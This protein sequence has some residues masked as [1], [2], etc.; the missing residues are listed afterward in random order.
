MSMTQLFGMLGE[1][2]PAE[3]AALLQRMETYKPP[4]AMLERPDTLES[5]EKILEMLSISGS[6]QNIPSAPQILLGRHPFN[7]NKVEARPSPVHGTGV[8]AT[9]TIKK[10]E[11]VTMYPGDAVLDIKGNGKANVAA[12]EKLLEFCDNSMPKLKEILKGQREYRCNVSGT[13][14]IYG[15]PGFA[16][17]PAY[18]G[19]MIND[20]AT[21]CADPRSIPVYMAAT[22]KKSNCK[23]HACAKNRHIAIL[24][25]KKIKKGRELFISY[26]WAYWVNPGSEK[27]E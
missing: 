19:H 25:T 13:V 12:S 17:D 1:L 22:E 21:A 3:Q 26:G 2:T 6:I 23:F 16:E 15:F 4:A 10:G 8:F 11:L 5:V 24:A 14:G 27:D 7:L 9:R 20:S 18:L